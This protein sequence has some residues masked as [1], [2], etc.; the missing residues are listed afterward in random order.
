MVAS[1]ASNTMSIFF[2][3][4]GERRKRREVES[5]LRKM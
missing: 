2:C 4:E 1:P 3:G 5:R